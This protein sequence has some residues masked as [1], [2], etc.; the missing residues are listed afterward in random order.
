VVTSSR[1]PGKEYESS[2]FNQMNIPSGQSRGRGGGRNALPAR[3]QMPTVPISLAK[4]AKFTEE[5]LY[6]RFRD[7]EPDAVRVTRFK[8][9]SILEE[10]LLKD[11]TQWITSVQAEGLLTSRKAELAMERARM[12]APARIGIYIPDDLAFQ[13]LPDDKKKQVLMSQKEWNSFRGSQGEQ[14]GKA[15][16]AAA[17]AA[18]QAE[19][20]G[21]V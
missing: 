19:P 5:K 14:G 17:Q 6:S 9:G 11:Q 21:S 12:R 18:T 13:A 8:G 20:K 1:T 15:P 2:K 16:Q 3:P 7:L 10:V 4:Q